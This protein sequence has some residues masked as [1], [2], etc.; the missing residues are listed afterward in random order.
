MYKLKGHRIIGIDYGAKRTGIAICDEFH[1]TTR[2]LATLDTISSEFYVKIHNIILEY[3]IKYAVIGIPFT[4]DGNKTEI[5]KE[6]ENFI[7]LLKSKF[8]LTVFTIDES[9]T[10]KR[11]SDIMLEIGIKKSKR[12]QKGSL[13]KIASALILK[14]F[15]DNFCE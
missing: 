6:I 8:D 5:I 13:D 2:P 14:D 1:I 9:N 10:S 4:K 3:D 12:K 7:K 15:I 11:A